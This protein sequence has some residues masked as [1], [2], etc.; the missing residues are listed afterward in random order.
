M[1]RQGIPAPL[2][3]GVC[4]LQQ[5]DNPELTGFEANIHGGENRRV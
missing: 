1:K 3:R 5:I 2:G 4:Q